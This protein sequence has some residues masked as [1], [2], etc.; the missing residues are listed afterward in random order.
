MVPMYAQKR[1][2]ASQQ[3]RRANRARS[4]RFAEPNAVRGGKVAG[5][6]THVY[7]TRARRPSILKEILRKTIARSLK[8]AI[9][10]R[11]RQSN[12][13]NPRTCFVLLAQPVELAPGPDLDGHRIVGDTGHRSPGRIREAVFTLQ[14]KAGV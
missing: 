3:P 13:P 11:V 6:E 2:E 4:F 9:E 5:P 7:F 14:R 12:L 8:L 1:M 10:K